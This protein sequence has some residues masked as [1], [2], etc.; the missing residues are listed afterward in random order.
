MSM[1][2]LSREALAKGVI[3]C[4]HAEIKKNFPSKR[5][6]LGHNTTLLLSSPVVAHS[7][8][9]VGA[10]VDYVILSAEPWVVGQVDVA[11]STKKRLNLAD[12]LHAILPARV[13][14]FRRQA[15]RRWRSVESD[16]INYLLVSSG[17][18]DSHN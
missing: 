10:K 6:G 9:E 2:E 17:Q 4:H 18:S 3:F 12:N 15:D 14:V 7:V 16:D 5:G 13:K 8:D 11:L 1:D